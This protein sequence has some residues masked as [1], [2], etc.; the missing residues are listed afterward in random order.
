MEPIRGEAR[1][2]M[3]EF[4][5]MRD[6]SVKATSQRARLV[7]I[8]HQIEVFLSF[9][10]REKVVYDAIQRFNAQSQVCQIHITEENKVKIE[11]LDQ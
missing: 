9:V 2:P 7:D 1:I 11:L 4:L 10:A 6:E 3:A 8:S 5:R